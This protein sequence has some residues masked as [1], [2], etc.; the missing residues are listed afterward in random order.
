MNYQINK[1]LQF[2]K[3]LL[4][5]LLCVQKVCIFAVNVNINRK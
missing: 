1:Q 5:F 3:Y 2:E 4:Y